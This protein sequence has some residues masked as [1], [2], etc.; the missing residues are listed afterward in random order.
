MSIRMVLA[1]VSLGL[2]FQ[3]SAD[4]RG[5]VWVYQPDGG[6]YRVQS[7]PRIYDPRSPYS[8]FP[9]Y[10][11]NLPPRMQ[12]Q[13]PP[14]YYDRHRG[15]GGRDWDRGRY[16]GWKQERH[17][18]FERPPRWHR[19]DDRRHDRPPVRDYR[20]LQQRGYESRAYRR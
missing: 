9:Q 17:G 13:L 4:S 5:G 20:A 10:R 19:H 11:Q 7:G 14:Q 18:R 8:N 6:S 15:N 1:A 2:A 16:Q 3:V 12:G